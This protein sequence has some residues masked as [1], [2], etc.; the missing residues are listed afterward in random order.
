MSV[1]GTIGI[2]VNG[3]HRRVRAGLTLVQ[4]INDLGLA[5]EKVAVERN[6]DVVPRGTFGASSSRT[7]TSWKSCISWA[8]ATGRWS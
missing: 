3:E 1:D 5:P 8:G 7:G 6:L 2:Q 4:L